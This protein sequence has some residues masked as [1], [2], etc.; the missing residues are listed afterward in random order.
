[1]AQETY[2]KDKEMGEENDKI[3]SFIAL[4]IPEGTQELIYK[5]ISSK[6]MRL[7]LKVS[8][9]KAEN[10]HITLKFL[11]DTM[12]S[13]IKRIN[14]GLKLITE[15]TGQIS[16]NCGKVGIFGSRKFPRVLW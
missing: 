13:R 5:T 12:F 3:R 11:G 1:M 2:N 15:K 6:F 8:W 16:L 7:P 10:M 4:E 9:V 14:S